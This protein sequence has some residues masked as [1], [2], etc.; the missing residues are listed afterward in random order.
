MARPTLVSLA[1][2]LGVSRQTVSNVINAPHLVK[3]ETRERVQEAIERSGYRP[4][5]AAQSLRNQCSRTLAMRIYPSSD[6]IYGAVM[7]RFHHELVRE[8]RARDYNIMPI[9]AKN[10]SD[11]VDQLI[12]LYDNGSIDACLLSGTS[13]Q[14]VRPAALS[15]RGLPMVAFGRPWGKPADQHYWV[16]VDGAGAMATATRTFLGQGHERVAFVGLEVG[17]GPGDDRR[18]GWRRVMGEHLPAQELEALDTQGVDCLETGIA[19]VERLLDRG[20][21]AFVC[22]TDSLALGA[23]IRLRELR[24]ETSGPLPVIGFDDSPVA[25]A[26]GMSSVAQPVETAV[27]LLVEALIQ[28]LRDPDGALPEPV[29]LEGDVIMRGPASR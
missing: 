3:Q 6:G 26:V 18:A 22:A 16:D 25:R 24:P 19:A 15:Q 23:S 27:R 2:E 9:T 13:A 1:K 29:L 20:A 17:S 10:D 21:T 28:Q 12:G 8:A 5:Q 11:E 7:D 4:N 14:D